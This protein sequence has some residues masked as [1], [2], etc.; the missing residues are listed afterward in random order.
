MK[1]IVTPTE[2]HR[3][4]EFV[5]ECGHCQNAVTDKV[6]PNCKIPSLV[7]IICRLSVKG[8]F[9]NVMYSFTMKCEHETN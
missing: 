4:V 7:C 5:V 6:C 8:N 3:G 9:F 2:A 1:C